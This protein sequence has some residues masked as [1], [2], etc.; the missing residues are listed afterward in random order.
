PIQSVNQQPDASINPAG[1]GTVVD[2]PTILVVEDEAVISRDIV[3]TLEMFEYYPLCAVSTADEAI[4][5]AREYVPD[6]V[7]MD[8][9]IHGT[10]D[11]IDA[12]RIIRDELQIPI[13]FI[14]SYADDAT[15]TRAKDTLPYGYI[16]KPFSD[17]DMKV[18]VEMALSRKSAEDQEKHHGDREANGA[19]TSGVVYARD[20]KPGLTE[21]R[22]LL[23]E[24]FFQDLIL[25]LYNNAEEKEILLASYLERAVKTTGDIFFAYAISKAH[26]DFLREVQD[27][28]ILL[29]RMKEGETSAL[30]RTL[31]DFLDRADGY[32]PAPRKIIIDFSGP[33][34]ESAVLSVTDFLT[35]RKNRGMAVAGII[36]VLVKTNDENLV[37]ALSQKIPKVLV[38]TTRGTVISCADYTFPFEHL[39]FLPQPVVDEIV[40]KVLEPVILSLLKKPVSGYD[41]LQEI[42]RRYNVSIPKARVYTYLYSLQKMGYLQTST[43]GKSIRYHPTEDGEKYIRQ[44]L[45]EFNSVFHHI[46]AEIVD[47]DSGLTIKDQRQEGEPR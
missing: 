9:H 3:K 43:A 33:C 38:T 14:T 15:I 30:K 5:K 13:I 7:L 24:N 17:R 4:S 16:L 6:V 27:E 10:M 28:K 35:E 40:K 31:S 2:K 37:K 8:I 25:L 36:A 21:I 22:S 23:M 45:S 12:A 1:P 18:A 32:S 29:C 47:R 39:A 44:K 26:R 34:D 42:Q 11:G 20:D 46:Q 19:E 41:I